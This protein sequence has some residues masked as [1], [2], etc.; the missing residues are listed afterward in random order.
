MVS[1]ETFLQ[2][3]LILKKSILKSNSFLFTIIIASLFLVLGIL[4]SD[5]C[6]TLQISLLNDINKYE[7]NLDPDFCD[8]LLNKIQNYNEQ[9]QPE[10][11]ILDCG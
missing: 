9:C 2:W 10:I 7:Q 5:S 6:G 8:A 3:K 11:E 1:S 4:L